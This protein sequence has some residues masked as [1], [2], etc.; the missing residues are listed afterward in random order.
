MTIPTHLTWE[1]FRAAY[2]LPGQRSVHRIGKTPAVEVFGDGVNQRVGLWLIMSPGSSVPDSVVGL[3]SIKARIVQKGIFS[4]LE[5]AVSDPDFYRDFYHFAL[6][7]SERVLAEG[8][9]PAD[10]VTIE[11]GSFADLLAEHRVLGLERQLGLIGELLVLRHLTTKNG[12]AALD[13]WVGPRHEPH[14]FRMG[15]TEL[16]VKT[17]TSTVRIHTINGLAQLVPSQNCSLYLFSVMLAPAGGS[18]D[19]FSLESLAAEIRTIMQ[20]T[21][22]RLDQFAKSLENAGYDRSHKDL[23]GRH[24]WIPRR[25]SLIAAVDNSFPRLTRAAIEQAAGSPATAARIDGLHYDVNIEGLGFAE[26]SPSF[27]QVF[28][29]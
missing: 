19:G 20:G 5:L 10:A 26:G 7:V 2:L 1:N 9:T 22:G 27:A 8:R 23:Y 4:A 24:K 11:I 28:P 17:T 12:P 3:A 15:P 29:A 13:A 14:D 16:E 18:P 6:A 25:G 21:P